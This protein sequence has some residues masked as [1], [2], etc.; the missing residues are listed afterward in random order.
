MSS[1]FAHAQTNS[2]HRML[3]YNSMTELPSDLFKA[4]PY[5]SY[6]SFF[7]GKLL[8][9]PAHVFDVLTSLAYLYVSVSKSAC[10][11]KHACSGISVIITLL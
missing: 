9:V 7:Q 6:V 1:M 10:S 8:T 4:T 5:L 3:G 11:S 2:C